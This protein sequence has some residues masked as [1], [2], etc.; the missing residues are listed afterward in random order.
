M[1]AARNVMREA[2]HRFLV[3]AFSLCDRIAEVEG[4]KRRRD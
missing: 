1:T 4:V 2:I 3:A